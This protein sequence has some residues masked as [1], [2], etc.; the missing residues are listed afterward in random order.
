MSLE[1]HAGHRP[2]TQPRSLAFGLWGRGSRRLALPG[3][4]TPSQDQK[5]SND[6]EPPK[7]KLPN[8]PRLD[9]S[10]ADFFRSDLSRAS[11]RNDVCVDTTFDECVAVNTVFRD[12]DL[13]LANV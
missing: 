12:A 2:V 7:E 6:A 11:L 4:A 8:K 10:G 5:P 3:E 13:S 9:L 1:G